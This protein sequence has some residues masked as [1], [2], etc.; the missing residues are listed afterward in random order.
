MPQ[1]NILDKIDIVLSIYNQEEIIERVLY[2]IFKNTTTPFNLI[3]IF[4][5]CRDRSKPRALRY[6]KQY[7]PKL[8]KEV[9]TRD[10]PNIFETR[11]NNT[12]FKLAQADYLITLQDDMVIN[13]HGWERR[14]TYP[15]RIFDDVLAVTSRTAQDIVTLSGDE[16]QYEHRASRELGTLSRETFAIRDVINRG[17]IAF[18]TDYLKEL[19]YLK[20]TYAPSNLDDADLSL[21]AW[22][23]KHWKVGAFW[24][25]Y[26]S[27]LEWGK[28]RAKDSMMIVSA[29]EQRHG[30]QIMHDHRNYLQSNQKHTADIHIPEN[31]I[32]YTRHRTLVTFYYWLTYPIRFT[33]KHTQKKLQ[34]KVRE[35]IHTLLP[36]LGIKNS[37]EHG[38]K[39]ILISFIKK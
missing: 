19:G 10:T 23:D 29:S 12:G 24:I 27:R 17:P 38:I 32:D 28:S 7:A 11:A 16:H 6:I 1:I 4:D 15:L 26:I 37:K 2:G 39:K 30:P 34:K 35:I 25:D 21:R 36:R 9:I 22:R 18:R 33:S 5:G 13:E 8:L 14:L 31:T 20:E 3:L